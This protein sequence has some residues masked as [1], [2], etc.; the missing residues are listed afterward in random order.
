MIF[1]LTIQ[2]SGQETK[3]KQWITQQLVDNIK[4][5]YN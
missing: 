2:V 3:M 5:V 1:V 4:I